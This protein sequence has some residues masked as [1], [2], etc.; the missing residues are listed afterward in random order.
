MAAINIQ[1]RTVKMAN[2]VSRDVTVL[3]CIYICVL[4]YPVTIHR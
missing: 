2:T 1:A 3:L 4:K